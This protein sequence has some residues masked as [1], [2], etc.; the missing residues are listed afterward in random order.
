MTPH[1]RWFAAAC[2]LALALPAHAWNETGHRLTALIAFELMSQETRTELVRT[3]TA[4]PR[5]EDDFLKQMPEDVRG[6]D[7]A[8]REAW[9]VAHASTWPDIVRGLEGEERERFHRGPWHYVNRPLFFSQEDA[10]RLGPGVA[11]N[12]AEVAGPGSDE[13]ELNIMQA[14]ARAMDRMRSQDLGDDERAVLLCWIMHLAGDAHQPMHSTALFSESLFPEGDRGGNSILV[15]GSRNLH[16]TW[17]DALG[18]EPSHAEAARRAEH[19]LNTSRHRSMLERQSDEASL[20]VW[21]D[22]SRELAERVAYTEEVMGPL[23][24]LER[25]MRGRRAVNLPPLELSP[26]YRERMQTVSEARITLAGVRLARA[27]ESALT[28]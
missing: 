25:A 13:A 26:S 17:D 3:L 28:P 11:V 2:L 15:V 18:R 4:H 12:Q 8:T 23:L 20:V 1:R 6:A 24:E 22:E 5:F 19:L 27:L 7:L 10:A 21:I 14:Y 9:I 16:A